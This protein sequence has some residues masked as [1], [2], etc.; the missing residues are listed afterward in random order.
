MSSLYYS[1]DTRTNQGT[2]LRRPG[3]TRRRAQIRSDVLRQ[4]A[5]DLANEQAQVERRDP[6]SRDTVSMDDWSMACVHL[7]RV[8][9]K[10][11]QNWADDYITRANVWEVAQWRHGRRMTR[12]L[13]IKLA[14]GE[15]SFNHGEMS[16]VLGTCFFA[17]EREPIPPPSLVTPPPS[18]QALPPSSQRGGRSNAEE[19]GEQILAGDIR[20]WLANAQVGLARN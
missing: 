11:K 12:I 16:D 19:D 13:A 15:L 17:R 6:L 10:A 9:R 4:A 2:S 7:G 3:D 1:G 14:S 20:I 18:T 5:E 8:T